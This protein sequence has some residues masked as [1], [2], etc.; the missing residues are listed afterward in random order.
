MP[1]ADRQKPTEPEAPAPAVAK[2]APPADTPVRRP[3]P[4]RVSAA[5]QPIVVVSS[6]KGAIAT[7]DGQLDTACTTPC[8]L[9][10]APGRHSLEL[11]KSGYDVERRDVDVGSSGVE[12]PAVVLRSVQGTL[13]LSSDP[14]GATVLVNG[15]RQPQVT[16][17]QIQL[18]P[19]SYSVTVEWKDGKQ[20]TRTVQIKDGINFQKFLLGQ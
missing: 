19:G 5:P 6:P 12:L 9:E 7:L 20:A 14:A 10:A 15:K 18:A 8:T 3:A 1:P 2:N 11:A 4:P 16:P 13:M 17:A